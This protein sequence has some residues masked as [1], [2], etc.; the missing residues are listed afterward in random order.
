MS[1]S[2]ASGT[3]HPARYDATSRAIHWLTA[4]LVL[5]GA[6]LGLTIAH[7]APEDEATKYTLYDIHESIGLTILA[8]TL[9]RLAWRIGHPAPPL[10]ADMPAPMRILA[11]ANHA[12]FYAWLLAMPVVGFVATNAWGFPV[13]LYGLIPL[14]DPVGKNVPLAETLTR[15][16]A[17]SGWIL[18][19]MIALH[20]TGALYD[21][22][23][24]H[25][26]TLDRMT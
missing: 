19:G 11:R 12:A 10:P 8:I 22:Y 15:I 18:L 17:V 9:F 1:A 26:G 16:H 21:Q 25:D 20:V 23:V 3:L 14:P 7:A 4:L 2:Q 6:A 24:R 5:A 13:K